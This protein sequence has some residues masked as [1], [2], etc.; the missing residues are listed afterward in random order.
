[1]W[2][3]VVVPYV[4]FAV[5]AAYHI[6]GPESGTWKSA[7]VGAVIGGAGGAVMQSVQTRKRRRLDAALVA[8]ED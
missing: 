3:L 5:G 1:M 2:P 7:I 4:V 6:G 8:D